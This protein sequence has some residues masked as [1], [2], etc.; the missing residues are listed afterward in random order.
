MFLYSLT[1][2]EVTTLS[3]V[4]SGQVNVI[5]VVCCHGEYTGV[6]PVALQAPEFAN[7]LNAL[8]SYDASRVVE[9]PDVG[10]FGI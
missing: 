4:N 3:N 8:G 7:Y 2:E 9:I 6:D 1:P 10:P 5:L